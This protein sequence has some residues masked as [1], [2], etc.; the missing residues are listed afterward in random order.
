MDRCQAVLLQVL[1][2]VKFAE[3]ALPTVAQHL[4]C[5]I[6]K[7]TNLVMPFAHMQ[8]DMI[9][10]RLKAQ[11][12]IAGETCS[13]HACAHNHISPGCANPKGWPHVAALKSMAGQAGR[14]VSL[15]YRRPTDGAK[16]GHCT[17]CDDGVAGAEHT[18]NI[19]SP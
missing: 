17:H 16:I 10:R 12:S 7:G 5:T 2:V 9:C 11:A 8:H 19:E 13:A 3:V 6:F 15:T 1:W 18:R 14:E 4:H